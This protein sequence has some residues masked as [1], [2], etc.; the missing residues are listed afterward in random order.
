MHILP[1]RFITDPALSQARALK[2][3]CDAGEL[4]RQDYQTMYTA[5]AQAAEQDALECHANGCTRPAQVIWDG[6]PLCAVCA[7]KRRTAEAL[8]FDDSHGR[9]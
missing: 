8:P 3:A 9:A 2:R 5:V 4:S 1:Q 6:I 7:L